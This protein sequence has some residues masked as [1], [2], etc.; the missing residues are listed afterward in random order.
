VVGAR[1]SSGMNRSSPEEMCMSPLPIPGLIWTGDRRRMLDRRPGAGLS[2]RRLFGLR[3]RVGPVHASLRRQRSGGTG[4]GQVQPLLRSRSGNLRSQPDTSPCGLPLPCSV[5]GRSQITHLAR[6]ALLKSDG[7]AFCARAASGDAAAPPRS[8]M[9]S[10]LPRLTRSPRRLARAG[11]AA[12]RGR[13]PWRFSDSPGTR[14]WSEP[15]SA[16]R[17]AFHP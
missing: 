3:C 17:P 14:T 7:L 4:A 13:V 1:S 11:S 10:R 2:R 12:R 6:L 16:S 9:N 8:V 5:S 15:V